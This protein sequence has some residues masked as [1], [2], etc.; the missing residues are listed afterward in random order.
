MHTKLTLRIE[1]PLIRAAKKYSKEHGKSL[2]Q[3]VADYLLCL[4]RAQSSQ[5]EMD[6]FKEL[7]P[8]TRSLKGILRGKKIAEK[9]YKK[10]LK[11]KF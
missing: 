2:S 6:D 3:L 8:L 11:D 7:P 5:P 1:E 4:T 9:D 10:Y